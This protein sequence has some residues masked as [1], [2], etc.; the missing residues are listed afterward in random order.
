MARPPFSYRALAAADSG[1]LQPI[2]KHKDLQRVLGC[3]RTTIYRWLAL[4]KLPA[5]LKHSNGRIMGWTRQQIEAL[6][7]VD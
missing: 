6:L 7:T 2:L 3:S 1:A 5:P 4:A